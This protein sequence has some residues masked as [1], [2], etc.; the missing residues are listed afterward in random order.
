[1]LNDLEMMCLSLVAQVRLPASIAAH[2]GTPEAAIADLVD[3]V[4]SKLQARNTPE[5]VAKELGNG[6]SPVRFR[7][8]GVAIHG[9]RWMFTIPGT[10]NVGGRRLQ[11]PTSPGRDSSLR[12]E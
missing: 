7:R 2:A 6:P 3:D 11:G 1:M 8:R 4:C 10:Y 9:D 12:I 5:A